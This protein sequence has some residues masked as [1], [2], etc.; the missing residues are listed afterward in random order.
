MAK[1]FG[2]TSQLAR[3]VLQGERSALARAITL[4][5]SARA[6]HRREAQALITELMPNTGK[7]IR[8]GL[9]GVPGVGKST[10]IDQFGSNITM[11]GHRVAVL[12][13]DPSSA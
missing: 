4:V 2:E 10:L 1:P 12:A 5:E 7:A 9:T 13:V 6:D 3:R 8:I 11:A